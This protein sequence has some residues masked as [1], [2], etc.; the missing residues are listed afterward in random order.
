MLLL[1][2]LSSVMAPLEPRHEC[3]QVNTVVHGCMGF[4]VS[5]GTE[6][7]WVYYLKILGSVVTGDVSIMLLSICLTW[8]KHTCIEMCIVFWSFFVWSLLYCTNGLYIMLVEIVSSI[9]C[10]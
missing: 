8:C 1:E 7:L 4:C 2:S 3:V 6:L 10:Q 9:I 5:E